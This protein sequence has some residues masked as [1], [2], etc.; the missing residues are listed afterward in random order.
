MSSLGEKLILGLALMLPLGV[1][2]FGL[3]S[4]ADLAA[5]RS[6]SEA[7]ASASPTNPPAVGPT[8]APRRYSALESAPPP[9]LTPYDAAATAE[10]IAGGTTPVVDPSPTPGSR[11]AASIGGT[12]GRGAVLRA[13][14]VSGR[15][16]AA[17]REGQV[18]L[19]LERR[20]VGGAE[21][22]RV[23]TEQGQ[24]GW[25]TGVVLRGTDSSRLP[26]NLRVDQPPAPGRPGA[27]APAILPTVA[28][29]D[30]SRAASR[31][32][33]RTRVVQRGD[34]L[35]GIAAEFGVS[36]FSI[37]AANPIPNPDSLTVGQVLVIP[38]Q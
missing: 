33:G 35:K 34:E 7:R 6:P 29:R 4:L 27:A 30:E 37:I 23:R 20:Q 16:V 24:E 17:L 2:A 13:E 15:P 36:I 9:T 12:D 38:E 11:E 31:A 21:W 32:G 22:A 14:P 10:A 5:V 28:A 3:P 26:G 8:S 18:I 19:V 25:V 1:V